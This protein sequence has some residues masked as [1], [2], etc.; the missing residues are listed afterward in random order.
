MCR[1]VEQWSARLAHNQQVAGS[2]PAPATKFIQ[3]IEI[4]TYASL[5]FIVIS[6]ILVRIL[7]GYFLLLSLC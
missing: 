3:Q 2:N 7:S 1:G 4:R 5:Y 6:V